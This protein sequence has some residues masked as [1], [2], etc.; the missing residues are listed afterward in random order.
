MKSVFLWQ[1]DANLIQER[2]R[3]QQLLEAEREQVQQLLARK[4]RERRRQERLDEEASE[5]PHPAAERDTSFSGQT[6]NF[7]LLIRPNPKP[8]AA[9]QAHPQSFAA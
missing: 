4:E 8:F 7:S 6:P 1:G 3:L 2:A 9:Y 5:P